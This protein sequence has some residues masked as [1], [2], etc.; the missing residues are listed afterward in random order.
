V[1][2]GSG[3]LSITEDILDEIFAPAEDT[4]EGVGVST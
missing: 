2:G 1:E 3:D 4:A